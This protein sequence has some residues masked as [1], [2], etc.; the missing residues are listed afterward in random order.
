MNQTVIET[1]ESPAETPI[2]GNATIG[3]I[4]DALLRRPGAI[5][6]LRAGDESLWLRLLGIQFVALLVYGLVTGLFSGGTQLAVA[7]LKI[8]LGFLSAAAISFPSFYILTCLS[9]SRATFRA[10]TSSFIGALTL[11]TVLLAGF[12]PIIW[13]FGE[14]TEGAVFMGALHVII[15]YFSISRAF[16]LLTRTLD[17]DRFV[18]NKLLA[19]W[20]TI[21]LLVV[22][23]MTTSLRPILGKSDHF[24]PGEKRFFAQHW[25][26]CSANRDCQAPAQ[27]GPAPQPAAKQS[28]WSGY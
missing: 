19:F 17:P 9:G 4:I 16:G 3:A 11:S 13:L 5:T 21:F 8:L 1:Q 20:T 18:G 24:F 7:P 22:F 12:V 26:L 28:G 23:Q 27:Q 10:I 6:V 14:S 25:M 15:S 2:E